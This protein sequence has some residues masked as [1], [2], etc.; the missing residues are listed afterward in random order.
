MFIKVFWATN[1]SSNQFPGLQVWELE[2]KTVLWRN[3]KTEPFWHVGIITIQIVFTEGRLCL[4]CHGRGKKQQNVISPLPCYSLCHAC[5]KGMNG[6]KQHPSPRHLPSWSLPP[7]LP[8]KSCEMKIFILVCWPASIWPQAFYL[9]I[10]KAPI[11]AALK[12]SIRY[13]PSLCSMSALPNSCCIPTEGEV[14]SI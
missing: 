7:R 12:C 1:P 6:T 8:G 5:S 2:E 14:I 13:G 10:S 11:S 9:N 3:F 4:V